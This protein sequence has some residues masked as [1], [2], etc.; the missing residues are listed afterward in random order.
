LLLANCGYQGLDFR[1]IPEEKYILACRKGTLKD[2]KPM[3]RIFL[4]LLTKG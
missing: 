2:Y 4:G 1:K 3:E